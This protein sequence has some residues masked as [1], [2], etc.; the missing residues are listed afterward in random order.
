MDNVKGFEQITDLASAQPLTVPAG[1]ER[2]W[3]QAETADVRY[4]LDGEDAAADVGMLIKAGAEQPTEI[5]TA[6]GLRNISVIAASG[7]PKLNVTY[8]G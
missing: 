6:A 3:L 2:A 7:S 1:T 5:S 4:R 8:F